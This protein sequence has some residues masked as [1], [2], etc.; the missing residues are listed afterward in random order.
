MLRTPKKVLNF[1]LIFFVVLAMTAAPAAAYSV[2]GKAGSGTMDVTMTAKEIKKNFESK[3]SRGFL[4]VKL[5]AYDLL[6]RI[7]IS[8]KSIEILTYVFSK[9]IKSAGLDK[10]SQTF[11]YYNLG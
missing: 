6:Y 1:M 2:T 5:Y 9:H 3:T 8:E 4:D 10:T 11:H 7:G